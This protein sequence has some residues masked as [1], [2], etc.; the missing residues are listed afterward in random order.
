MNLEIK[1]VVEVSLEKAV[2]TLNKVFSDYFVPIEI[3]QAGFLRMAV[4]EAIDLSLSR[5]IL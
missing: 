2:Y 3:D 4:V 5:I 1:S